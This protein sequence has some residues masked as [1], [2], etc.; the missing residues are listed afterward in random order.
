MIG[1]SDRERY[2]TLRKMKKQ[3]EPAYKKSEKNKCAQTRNR[4]RD[5]TMGMLYFTTKLFA[6]IFMHVFLK[7][8]IYPLG[9]KPQKTRLCKKEDTTYWG[10]S[11]EY[12]L[13][14]E[15]EDGFFFAKCDSN[16]KQSPDCR[17]THCMRAH[18]PLS[19]D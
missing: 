5:I 13:S 17:G 19:F 11:Y 15:G 2:V 4:T 8:S 7:I 10:T 1:S 16:Y 9:R 6:P 14:Y 18:K 12:K 3:I